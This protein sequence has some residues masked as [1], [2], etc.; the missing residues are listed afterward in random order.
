VELQ[1]NAFFA[2]FA[3]KEP[4]QESIMGVKFQLKQIYQRVNGIPLLR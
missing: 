4:E 3:A 1:K 2:T